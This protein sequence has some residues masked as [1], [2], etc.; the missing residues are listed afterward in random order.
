MS[1]RTREEKFTRV[2]TE[3]ELIEENA[4]LTIRVAALNKMVEVAYKEGYD[5]GYEASH[6]HEG[7]Y[8]DV[9]WNDSATK[10]ELER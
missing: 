9:A 3:A 10:E 1:T 2:V 6:W 8:K 5:D 7:D 4:E